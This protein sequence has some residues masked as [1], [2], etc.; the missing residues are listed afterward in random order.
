MPFPANRP[1]SRRAVGPLRAAVLV[2]AGAA[3]LVS[4]A[5]ADESDDLPADVRSLL[6]A[7]PLPPV[8]VGPRRRYLALVHKRQLLPLE[9]LAEPA[10]EL[11]GRRINVRTAARH[12]PIDYY[13]V[14]VVDLRSGERRQIP[15]PDDAT[16]GFPSW[17]PDG[18]KFAF[19]VR[20]GTGT[21]LWVA[22]PRTARAERLIDGL[23]AT[24]GTPCT[25]TRDSRRLLCKRLT[26][27]GI[28][29]SEPS[30]LLRHYAQQSASGRPVMLSDEITR[31]LLESQLVLT[32]SVSGHRHAIGSPAAVESV[33][34]APAGAVLLVSRI[35]EPYPRVSGVDRVH[36]VTELWDRF[37]NMIRR[38]PDDARAVGWHATKPAVLT[39]IE[40]R[41]GSDHLMRLAPPYSG[42]ADDVFELHGTFSG[43]RWLGDT[44][45]AIVNDYDSADER[46]TMWRVDFDGGRSSAE[47]L[48]EYASDSPQLP[49]MRSN[50][51]G[52]DA[53]LVHDGGFYVRGE[54]EQAEGG[55]AFLDR[56]SI[57]TG[58]STRI[59][60]SRKPGYET[61][62]DVLS[63]D[64]ERLLTRHETS[65]KPPNYFVTERGGESLWAVT[66]FEHPAPPLGDARRMRLAYERGDGVGLSASL[67]LPP[68][69]EGDERLPLVVWAYPHRVTEG[70][71]TA[72]AAPVEDRFPGFERAFRLFF[73]LRGYAV[74]DH[75][76]MPIV[77]TRSDANDTFVQ[78]ITAN[79][80]AAIDAA[81]A[82]GFVD[83]SRVGVAGHSY[84]AFMVANLLAHSR[85]FDAGA[86]L[87]GAY[88]R[89][90]TPFG[91][92]T[93]RRT[94]W[95]APETYLAM[96]P[97]LYSHRIEA[98]LLLVHGML[99]D[100]AGTAPIQS[101]QFYEAI[102]G[103]GGDAGLLLLPWEGHSYRARESVMQTAG[104]MLDWFDRHVKDKPDVEPDMGDQRVGALALP[105]SSID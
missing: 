36:R 91:F 10:I 18:S 38:V 16:V 69:Y 54:R 96:S 85:L 13:A 83:P 57:E 41:D 77:G 19:T 60:E 15:L 17:A 48:T 56:V 25:W 78:Q 22:D 8:A 39:W 37:G 97:I 76:S 58:E 105:R 75:A 9:R 65:R 21:E 20:R 95:E 94:F 49:I 35:L 100:N 87:S 68:G 55:R 82:T 70:E 11:A 80:S 31:T 7:E 46:T 53:V 50:S 34:S 28:S 51:R 90:L 74:L 61:L 98:P 92:Q 23:N 104:S 67:H 2:L 64:G 3:L 59:W 47:R 29:G 73:L 66:D 101:T 30:S 71:E 1:M 40:R 5:R 52:H 84:G 45:A 33:R 27:G 4:A 6:E 102:R 62:V 89:T 63:M 14:T 99:D 86:A 32:D 42:P 103:N 79:A 72:P 26:H 93:E 81:E 24:R 88:N 12:A 44:G 43:L